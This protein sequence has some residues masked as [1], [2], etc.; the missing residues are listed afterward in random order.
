MGQDS[1][2]QCSNVWPHRHFQHS[3]PCFPGLSMLK[4]MKHRQTDMFTKPL[5]CSSAALNTQR[6]NP[7]W[8]INPSQLL[9]AEVKKELTIIQLLGSNRCKSL[10]ERKCVFIL[11]P[12]WP[13]NEPC[14]TAS[15]KVTP[16][17]FQ[18]Q[19]MIFFF[20]F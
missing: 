16:L 1:R 15:S 10:A 6:H 11:L 19:I 20:F 2:L 3:A 12:H 9:L 13:Q 18:L 17:L 7:D 4:P 5:F 14:L 8:R